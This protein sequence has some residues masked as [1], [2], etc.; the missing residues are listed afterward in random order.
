MWEKSH[1]DVSEAKQVRNSG[2]VGEP[3]VKRRALEPQLSLSASHPR[4]CLAFRIDRKRR[5]QPYAMRRAPRRRV[6]SIES[7]SRST[8]DS[9]DYSSESVPY[10]IARVTGPSQ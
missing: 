5:K 9:R 7:M 1:A 4:T 3:N 10:S 8:T 6:E 2:V